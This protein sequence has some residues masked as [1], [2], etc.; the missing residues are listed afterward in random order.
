M[1]G[2]ASDELL[3]VKYVAVDSLRTV[4]GSVLDR[5]VAF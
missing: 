5:T 2:L 3:Q 1:A 4:V